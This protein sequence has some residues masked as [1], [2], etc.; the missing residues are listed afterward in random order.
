MMGGVRKDLVFSIR[1]LSSTKR[2]AGA[3]MRV[4]TGELRHL[5]AL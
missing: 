5:E 4:G 2:G 1:M 3:E